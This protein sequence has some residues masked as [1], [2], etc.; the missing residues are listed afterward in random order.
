[1]DGS[2]WSGFWI[3]QSNTTNTSDVSI[4]YDETVAFGEPRSGDNT[5]Y[6]SGKV[7][8][9]KYNES[10]WNQIGQTLELLDSKDEDQFGYSVELNDTGD[11]LAVV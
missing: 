11:I 7:R 10:G 5:P 3:S 6:N 4:S 2:N 1:M 8:I 9:F